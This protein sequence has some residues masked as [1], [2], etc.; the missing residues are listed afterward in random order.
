MSSANS[1]AAKKA[2]PESVYYAKLVN[3]ESKKN[4][5]KS[6]EDNDS[7]YNVYAEMGEYDEPKFYEINCLMN[8]DK[9]LDDS[10]R[11][12]DAKRMGSES[13]LNTAVRNQMSTF[14][15]HKQPAS[16]VKSVK[17]ASSSSSGS[18]TS[19]VSSLSKTSSPCLTDQIC[20][21]LSTRFSN[22]KLPIEASS[23]CTMKKQTSASHVPFQ[24]STLLLK[25]S[26]NS[27]DKYSLISTQITQKSS[28]DIQMDSSCSSTSSSS[29]N[30]HS[31]RNAATSSELSTNYF[32]KHKTIEFD[33]DDLLNKNPSTNATLIKSTRIQHQNRN[34]LVVLIKESNEK[35]SKN[36]QPAVSSSSS[37]SPISSL[38]STSSSSSS[39]QP[40]KATSKTTSSSSSSS[41]S[42]SSIHNN[43]LTTNNAN[44]NAT[45]NN[46][47]KTNSFLES[48]LLTP[49]TPI[50]TNT[51]NNDDVDVDE[52]LKSIT[53][54][55]GHLAKQI[56]NT[57]NNNN[58][59]ATN[60]NSSCRSKP[61]SS[62]SHRRSNRHQH[63]LATTNTN[64]SSTSHHHA[65]PN[66]KSIKSASTSYL[67]SKI[68]SIA[69]LTM[70]KPTNVPHTRSNTTGVQSPSSTGNIMS[71]LA[72][73]TT[74]LFQ[75]NKSTN[76]HHP[77]DT[78]LAGSLNLDNSANNATLQ[79]NTNN[80]YLL[81]SST[82][83]IESPVMYNEHGKQTMKPY[84][85]SS[86][87]SASSPLTFNGVDNSNTMK[88]VS[89]N[90]NMRTVKST[91]RANECSLANSSQSSTSNIANRIAS[92]RPFKKRS[93]STPGDKKLWYYNQNDDCWFTTSSASAATCNKATKSGDVLNLTP[94]SKL[95]M[96]SKKSSASLSSFGNSPSSS[97]NMMPLYSSSSISI[98]PNGIA[99]QSPT[100]NNNS[101]T[102]AKIRLTD[103]SIKHLTLLELKYLKQLCFNKLQIDFEAL[104]FTGV[105]GHQV[106]LAIPKD[107]SMKCIKTKNIASNRSKSVDFRFFD[108]IK[109]NYLSKLGQKETNEQIFGQ[110]LYKC[111]I[112]DLQNSATIRNSNAAG[113]S[114]PAKSHRINPNNLILA[115]KNDM[116]RLT[117]S[118]TIGAAAGQAM[119]K[120]GGGES[121]ELFN[122]RNSVLFEA[123]DLKNVKSLDKQYKY[124]AKSS[125]KAAANRLN[126]LNENEEECSTMLENEEES[127]TSRSSSITKQTVINNQSLSIRSEG[128]VPNIVKSCCKHISEHGLDVVGIFR[129]DSSKKRIKEI[130]ELFDSGKQ[131]NFDDSYTANDVACILKEYLRSLPEPLLTCDLY[132]G[133]LA[134][135]RVNDP[136]K[137]LELVRQLICLLPAPNRDTLQV[138]LKLLDKVRAYAVPIEVNSEI[139]GG[140]KMDAFNLA[141]VF[142]PNLLK[143]HKLSQMSS[144]SKMGDLNDKY[145]LVDDIDAVITCTKFLIEQQNEIFKIESEL[146][147]ELMQVINSLIPNEVNAILSSKV[148]ASYGVT[149]L[150][151]VPSVAH[152][153]NN[154]DSSGYS[155]SFKSTNNMMMMPNPYEAKLKSQTDESSSPSYSSSTNELDGITSGM[156]QLSSQQ[157]VNVDFIDNN[158]D[159]Y[160]TSRTK[161]HKVNTIN[162]NYVAATSGSRLAEP[163]SFINSPSHSPTATMPRMSNKSSSSTSSSSSSSSSSYNYKHQQQQHQPN[164]PMYDNSYTYD[165]GSSFI[166]NGTLKNSSSTGP[167]GF[168]SS[169]SLL[170][171]IQSHNKQQQM[172][173]QQQLNKIQMQQAFI[174]KAAKSLTSL[175]NTTSMMA[176]N[177][178]LEENEPSKH[179]S[180]RQISNAKLATALNYPTESY[181]R[182][183]GPFLVAKCVNNYQQQQQSASTQALNSS[184]PNNCSTKFYDK[185][186]FNLIG[187][188]ETLV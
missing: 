141:M 175:N 133:F 136:R 77:N 181:R 61:G 11:P 108:E 128:L 183:S 176:S 120:E 34:D 172:Q 187:E 20:D 70:N 37:S 94:T 32:V 124:S 180:S 74:R 168:L 119:T 115:T 46:N 144:N 125:S 167:N 75:R 151:N 36:P 60:N 88:T 152:E 163:I 52:Q 78:D 92:R 22:F 48:T 3:F 71:H 54:N 107:E 16:P 105:L 21:A 55:S 174:T 148:A 138:L 73:K 157:Y 122:K 2:S 156:S 24:S 91:S 131:V 66:N 85:Y 154:S 93:Q 68:T 179:S 161:L 72:N 118:R 81:S 117:G 35:A 132:A 33:L 121:T 101:S 137:R 99:N 10:S 159:R 112:N 185:T 47:N 56:K 169:S 42:T 134:T 30:C 45:N 104:N 29:T 109:E 173:H 26:P 116:N 127:E 12:L 150:D 27:N 142:A 95:M 90:N 62:G 17:H 76:Q 97:P 28:F 86:S 102:S 98:E 50:N 57:S 1:G 103:I 6:K 4:N 8:A 79:L 15:R 165:S 184:N 59:L 82:N 67:I 114:K 25:K 43:T 31:T 41:S 64:T 139:L 106:K 14:S 140:N 49:L 51:N 65:K 162:F 182:Q 123:L 126:S 135:T 110:S 178:M 129:I 146:H 188:Q 13:S 113:H 87:S 96:N 166:T 147:N 177:E 38:S 170:M 40:T 171:M 89:N 5:K 19:S 153:V 39:T 83:S 69:S 63:R 164:Q 149:L 80:S 111:I 7:L 100:M 9:D 158:P 44:T 53:T 155:S 23:K 145:S 84:T 58:Y 160:R 186:K 130:K 18:E 143:R